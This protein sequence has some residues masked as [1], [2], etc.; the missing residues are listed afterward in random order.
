MCV[1]VCVCVCVFGQA[2]A[3]AD[4]AFLDGEVIRAY[5]VGTLL[6]QKS[7]SHGFYFII[8]DSIPK[9]TCTLAPDA[10]LWMVALFVCTPGLQGG[11]ADGTTQQTYAGV[12]AS[13]GML[14]LL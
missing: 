11:G 8:F 3:Q 2:V 14:P 7:S 13:Y 1:C 5:Q 6:R 12:P 10:V 9:C 4:P